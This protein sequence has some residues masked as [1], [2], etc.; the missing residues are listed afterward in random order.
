MANL[1]VVDPADDTQPSDTGTPTI[2]TA[3]LDS[4]ATQAAPSPLSASSVLLKMWQ[5]HEFQSGSTIYQRSAIDK[6]MSELDP[7]YQ[8]MDADH[9]STFID[10]VA[11]SIPT[12]D[13][14]YYRRM[15][16]KIYTPALLTLGAVGAE[17]VPGAAA[18]GPVAPTL[19]VAGGLAASH[20]MDTAIGIR[21]PIATTGGIAGETTRDLLEGGVN[22]AAGEV[23]GPL[24]GGMNLSSA[25]RELVESAHNMGVQIPAETVGSDNPIVGTVAS[26]LRVLPGSRQVAREFDEQALQQMIKAHKSILENGDVN[27]SLEQ[28]GNAIQKHLDDFV[29][30]NTNMN[31]TQA[32]KFKN[33]ILRRHGSPLSYDE[34]GTNMQNQAQSYFEEMGK[35]ADALYEH[36]RNAF[37]PNFKASIKGS[38][39]MAHNMRLQAMESMPQFQDS[40]TNSLLKDLSGQSE[41]E[42]MVAKRN[43]EIETAKTQI[44][45]SMP[46]G[47]KIDVNDPRIASQLPQPISPEEIKAFM[48]NRTMPLSKLMRLRSDLGNSIRA[49]DQ[50][51]GFATGPTPGFGTIDSGMLKQVHGTVSE[52]I[53]GAFE[54]SSP[55][56]QKAYDAANAFYKFYMGETDKKA[57]QGILKSQSPEMIYSGLVK[58][59]MTT[60][61]DMAKRALPPQGFQDIQSRFMND[62]LDS[63]I[64]PET[65]SNNPMTGAFVRKQIAKWTPATIS[66]ILDPETSAAILKLPEQLDS[67]PPS[68]P[69]NPIFKKVLNSPGGPFVIDAIFRKGGT[70]NVSDVMDAM[71]PEGQQLM[72]QSFLAKLLDPNTHGQI[73]GAAMDSAKNKYGQDMMDLMFP[74]AVEQK[75]VGDFINLAYRSKYNMSAVQNPPNTAMGFMAARLMK[76]L[77]KDPVQAMA[78]FLPTEALARAYY[79]PT[80][81]KWLTDGM[82]PFGRGAAMPVA[83]MIGGILEGGGDESANR[84]KR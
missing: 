58:P 71:D 44:T 78:Q 72:R 33:A 64:D 19:G 42:A 18:S 24:F 81:Q 10:T 67:L 48:D 49:I 20:A 15:A 74:N 43:A 51:Q 30:D 62:F 65:G 61:I 46:A 25:D 9:R 34:L 22:V 1:A 17:A 47:F 14:L 75:K 16:S 12:P 27:L 36:A 66:R 70:Q 83:N 45:Q 8:Q 35:S 32:L 13:P 73:S 57:L 79:S 55:E 37:D 23:L 63:G 80:I 21:K 7:E 54:Q 28:Y 69:D 26:A 39:E 41:I 84:R 76:T 68:L 29:R 60:G 50:S 40:T 6:V 2:S 5:D 11:K 77:L 4:P 59:G 38:Q 31:T 56:A 3:P 82:L 52:D 53:A